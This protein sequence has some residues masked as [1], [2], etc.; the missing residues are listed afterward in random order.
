MLD[1][2][3]ALGDAH[4]FF[5]FALTYIFS[6][7]LIY[8]TFNILTSYGVV[9]SV[10]A[11]PATLIIPTHLFALS[12]AF[13]GVAVWENFSN[14][15]DVVSR[16]GEALIAYVNY[17]DS[18]PSLKNSNLIPSVKAYA[19]SASGKEWQ[20]IATEKRRDPQ[21]DILLKDL[22]SNTLQVASNSNLSNVIAAG[23]VQAAQNINVTRNA[24][25]G[26]I[27]NGRPHALQW[28]CVL[29]LGFMVQISVLATHAD[30][31]RKC[32]SLLVIVTIS[33]LIVL[34]LIG[35]SVNPYVG[36]ISV[37]HYPLQEILGQKY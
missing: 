6:G 15:F 13:L 26:M 28:Y 29:L 32:K 20:M 4:I 9:S 11:I 18:I 24:R 19:E 23:L 3:F 25:L 34:T 1:Q 5:G 36:S 12:S 10:A 2:F 35:L 14:H 8:W 7:L 27:Y 16:E 30:N 22:I 31:P 17:V 21:T 33:M 37:S